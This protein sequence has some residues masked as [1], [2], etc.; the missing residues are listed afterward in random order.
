MGSGEVDISASIRTPCSKFLCRL[1]RHIGTFLEYLRGVDTSMVGGPVAKNWA[2]LS[3]CM[4][5]WGGQYLSF[6]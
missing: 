6:Y 1:L 5:K 4:G 3:K 2:K